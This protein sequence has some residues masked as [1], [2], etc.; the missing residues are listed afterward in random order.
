MSTIQQK[1][2][3]PA[4]FWVTAILA[5][6]WNAIGVFAYLGQAFMTDEM[7]TQLPPEQLALMEST[8]SWVTAAFAIA[9]WG[10]LLGSLAL[11]LRKK[12]SKPV[13]LTSLL[14]ILGQMAYSIFMTNAAEIYGTLQ[15]IVLPML[16]IFIGILLYLLAGMAIR[17]GWMG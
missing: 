15:G 7:K 17:K 1:I 2:K 6:I 11:L 16:V 5:L 13:F 12:W 8:P 14:A 9:V 4:W 3:P 10:G